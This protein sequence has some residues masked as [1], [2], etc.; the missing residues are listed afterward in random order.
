MFAA[1]NMTFTRVTVVTLA[2]TRELARNVSDG[3][4]EQF[5]RESDQLLA[6]LFGRRRLEQAP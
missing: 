2:P 5:G 6:E 1:T 3:F 4:D